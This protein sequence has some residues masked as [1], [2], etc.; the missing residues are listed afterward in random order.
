MITV[1]F[2]ELNLFMCI[3]SSAHPMA[4]RSLNDS[5]DSFVSFLIPLNQEVSTKNSFHAGVRA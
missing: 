4:R 3:L 2:K 5:G 1:R